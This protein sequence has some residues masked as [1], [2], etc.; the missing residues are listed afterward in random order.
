MSAE[1]SDTSAFT[2]LVVCS[3][4][5]CRSAIGQQLLRARFAELGAEHELQVLS[6]GTIAGRADTMPV[7]AEQVSRRYGGRPD[8]HLSTPLSEK[9][10]GRSQLVLTATRDHRAIVASLLPRASR[11]A[12][13]FNQFARLAASVEPG[14]LDAIENPIDRVAA[15][16]AQRGFAPPERP[17][18]DDTDDPFMEPIEVYERVAAEIDAATRA[19]A[20]A[21]TRS[22][23]RGASAAPNSAG[24]GAS[25]TP[26]S[27]GREAS[28]APDSAG[29]GASA[30]PD[31]AGRGAS[32]SERLETPG[33]PHPT[34]PEPLP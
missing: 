5:I 4:N 16:A 8:G 22:A 19:I 20:T 21:L 9:L 13:T 11:I 24:R 1:S 31:S 17:E 34:R 29:R 26:N 6:A 30:A 2:I 18:D 3:G 12:F 15:I 32:A 14:E 33:P 7:E 10:I 25:A 23:G 27:A 28:A